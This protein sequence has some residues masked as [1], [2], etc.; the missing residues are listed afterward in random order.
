[1]TSI[2]VADD[3]ALVRKG[4]EM[5]IKSAFKP[6][7]ITY[8]INGQEVF[9]HMRKRSYDLVILDLNM[10]DTDAVALFQHIM[11]LHPKQR[12]LICSMNP[13]KIFAM[14]YLKLGATGYVEKSV[15]DDI[16]ERAIRTVLNGRRYFSEDML[17]QIAGAVHNNV[18]SNPFDS[19]TDREFEIALH[20]IKGLTVGEIA[21]MI[22]VHTS[23]VG[24]QRARILEKTGVQN[25]MELN[26]LARTHHIVE[27]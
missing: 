22:R 10:P 18:P 3:H 17:E 16:L 11:S 14:R 8:A 1:M 23:T 2:L 9:R 20:L 24:T 26:Q 12:V 15:N 7:E 21:Q 13:E 6:C 19:L 5:I 4:L 27:W 25:V